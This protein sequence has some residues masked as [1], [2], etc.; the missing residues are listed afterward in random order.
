MVLKWKDKDISLLSTICK[1]D[2]I[3]ITRQKNEIKIVADY[4]INMG[5]V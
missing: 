2:M 4:K 1:T 5:G 3:A